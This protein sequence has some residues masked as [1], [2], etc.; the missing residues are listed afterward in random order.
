VKHALGNI[1]AGMIV[2]LAIAFFV[3]ALQHPSETA[4]A[5]G[6]IGVR[7][8]EMTP[9]EFWRIVAGGGG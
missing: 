1:A 9:P 8:A 2:V 5:V 4:Q 7:L 3:L 6:R